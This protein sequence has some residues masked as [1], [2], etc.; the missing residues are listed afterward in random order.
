[1]LLATASHP[2]KSQNIY[3]AK[4]HAPVRVISAEACSDCYLTAK[5]SKLLQSCCYGSEKHGPL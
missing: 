1:M 5:C 2:T 3:D 4:A